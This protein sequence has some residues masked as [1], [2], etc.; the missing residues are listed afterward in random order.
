M[1][2]TMKMRRSSKYTLK[3]KDNRKSDKF[4]CLNCGYENHSDVVGAINIARQELIVPVAYKQI[5]EDL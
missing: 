3:F 5:L 2:T 4:L 1:L